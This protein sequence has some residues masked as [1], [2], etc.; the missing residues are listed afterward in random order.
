MNPLGISRLI[1]ELKRRRVFRGVVFYGASTLLVL[2]AAEIIY[3]AFG[4]E[5][6]PT[7]LILLLAIGF[8]VSLWFSWIYDI[9]PGGIRKT[10]AATDRAV[11]IPQ[12]ELTIYK[13]TTFIAVLIIIG[14]LSY[15]IVDGANTKRIA[16][17]DKT[18]AVLPM[19]DPELLREDLRRYEFIGHEITSC[20]LNVKDYI[21]K[22]WEECRNYPRIES[23]TYA[24]MGQ[25]LSAAI[26]VNWRPHETIDEKYLSVDLISVDNESLL[27]S[28]NYKIEGNWPTEII[29]YSRKISKK[30]TRKLRTYLTPE[31]RAL[32]SEEPVSASATMYASMGAAMTNDIWERVRTGSGDMDTVKSEYID[33]LSFDRAI[34]F[35]TEA[36][37]ENPN[38]AEA[39]ARRA[40]ARIW[41]ID[42]AYIE[43]SELS[44]S[45]ADI[46]RAFELEPDLPEAHVAMGFFYY[47]GLEDYMLA[48]TSLERAV[49]FRPDHAEYLF[50]LS[51][52][53]RSLG[54]WE[55]VRK[56]SDIIFEANPRNALFLTNLGI[57]YLYLQ[58]FPKAVVCQ[59]RAIALIP[60]WDS[61][62]INKIEALISLGQL[63]EARV[64]V[65]ELHENTGQEGYRMEAVIDL[66]EK[67][68]EDAIDHIKR[69][70]V[71]EFE[72][73]GQTPGDAY[74][75]NA[76]IYKH[77]GHQ[78]EA[79]AYYSQ[80]VDYFR[81]QLMFHPD[82]YTLCSKLGIAYAGTG[83]Y[84]EAREYGQ[85]AFEY[86]W[87]QDPPIKIIPFILHDLIQLYAIVGD[88]ETAHRMMTLLL[89]LNTYFTA[90]LLQYDP[91]I[92]LIL[93]TSG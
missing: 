6:V 40:K 24:D 28:E 87:Q 77:A 10:E 3:N 8:L 65:K 55:E 11:S 34:Q 71:K 49:Y 47:Y 2:E 60:E 82:D 59:E 22:P 61:P 31:E 51:L 12:K 86:T 74:L 81:N 92:Q 36:I 14:L 69:A 54:H 20:L 79:Q 21:V 23:S 17:I 38:Y 9:T 91:D 58:N 64:V 78:K 70:S 90:G 44:H 88:Q 19:N 25:D 43:K 63:P 4:I 85:K 83:A 67:K 18:I 29:R 76:K 30:I 16:H 42:A 45:E 5:A 39:Y 89:D 7:W 13:S 35:F 84:S 37:K 62:Y 15:R 66:Y 75:L 73:R 68:Y 93:D 53:R 72:R 33:S 56:L 80:A 46:S 1:N 32:I 27:W 48:L 52:V 26:L 41:G 50:Y 57:S